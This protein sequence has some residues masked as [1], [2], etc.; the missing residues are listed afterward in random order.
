MNSPLIKEII[1]IKIENK[2]VKSIFFEYNKNVKPGQFFMI[3]IP[4]IDEIPMSVSFI[5]K[6]IKAITFKNVGN[7]TNILNK[8]KI[9]DKIGIRGPY[10][11]G[12]H[13]NKNNKNKIY[14]IS[15]GTGI[16][17]LA[18]VID[19]VNDNNLTYHI[20]LGFK[21]KN[22]IFFEKRFKKIT[23]QINISTNDGSKGFH[24]NVT[25]L[26]K[27]II[28]ENNYSIMTC[29]PEIMMKELF[30]VYC[31]NPFQASLERY[32]KCAVGL[33]GQCCIGKGLRVCVEGPVFDSNLLNNI[34]EFGKYK[35]NESG[36]IKFFK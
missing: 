1:D 26:S 21:N 14:F 24:G 34:E 31:C 36:N 2:F 32:M 19:Y 35:R 12:F 23:N 29:G 20:L 13:I 30:K 3:W 18:P 8:Y 27:E 5:D 22:E 25:D 15:G 4:T 33:C 16:A 6:K 10:G 28:K 7:A 9:G 11:N 17:T